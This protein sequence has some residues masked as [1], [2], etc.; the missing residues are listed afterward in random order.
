MTFRELQDITLRELGYNPQAVGEEPRARVKD[1]LNS[2][3]R[4]LLT[5]PGLSRYLRDAYSLT[6]TTVANQ[7]RYGLPYAVERIVAVRDV[8]NQIALDCIA[9]DEIRRGDP[10]L[11]S[12]G[13]PMAYAL[14]GQFPVHTQPSDSST[15]Y[16]V[17]S[18][19][20]D[21][22]QTVLM[23]YINAAGKQV[24]TSAVLTG[25][26]A[27]AIGTTVIEVLRLSLTS[28]TTGDVTLTED[29]GGGTELAFIPAGDTNIAHWHILLYPVP[30]SAVTLTL[31]CTRRLTNL[32]RDGDEPALP[33]DFHDLL[34]Y[35]AQCDEWRRKGELERAAI[36]RTEFEARKK[37]LVAWTWNLPG[38]FPG[39]QSQNGSPS[40][41]GPWFPSGS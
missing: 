15:L 29:A 37:D 1:R 18:S 21:I 41:L 38:Y 24:N 36:V 4:R 20:Y 27:V 28:S 23:E 30:A 8:T 40:R 5:E 26:T 12:S 31:D 14:L 39:G 25:L 33:R 34:S 11:S 9:L 17:S 35:A 10:G 16:V 19:G 22:T 2:W 32:S 3:H 13:D 7:S 6:L